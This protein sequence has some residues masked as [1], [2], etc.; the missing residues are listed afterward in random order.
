MIQPSYMTVNEAAA[1]LR[2][3]RDTICRQIEGGKLRAFKIGRQWRIAP[4]DLDALTHQPKANRRRVNLTGAIA[5][6]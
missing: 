1:M 5:Y 4:C 2:V 3:S 6:Y